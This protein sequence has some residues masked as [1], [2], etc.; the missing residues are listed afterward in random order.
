MTVLAAA[1]LKS[2]S[3]SRPS[4]RGPDR[5]SSTFLPSVPSLGPS[6]TRTFFEMFAKLLGSIAC[7]LALAAGVAAA[8]GS[9]RGARA[10]ALE[11][12]QASL[13]EALEGVLSSEAASKRSA[14]IE[15]RVWADLPGAAQKRRG[16]PRTEGCAVP[17]AQ[18]FHEGARLAHPGLGSPCQPGRRVGGP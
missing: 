7:W 4:C 9:F 16:P 11:E 14:H 18:L 17:G 13:Q 6:T 2:H 15:A 8:P 1:L 5:V 10:V 3:L 12:I